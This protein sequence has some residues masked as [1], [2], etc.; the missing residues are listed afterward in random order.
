M[1]AAYKGR[2]SGSRGGVE[3]VGSGLRL[4]FRHNS[5]SC[6]PKKLSIATKPH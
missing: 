3:E 2:V 1:S 5:T 4:T 6:V